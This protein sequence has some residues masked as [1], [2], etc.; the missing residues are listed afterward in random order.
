MM[1]PP[2]PIR[3]SNA[4]NY[5]TF[6]TN[7]LLR[8]LSLVL[9]LGST[10]ALRADPT[11]QIDAS[12]VTAQ[13]S[14]TLYG[15]M[16]EEIN[17]SYEGGLYGELIQNRIFRDDATEPKHW[18][19]V[20]DS[21]GTGTISLDESQPIEGTVLTRAL[22]LDA[23]Q[24]ST[25]H[26]VGIAN[27]GYWGI[28]VKPKTTY[29]LSFYAKSDGSGNGPLT[30]SIESN[31]GTKVFATAQVPQ[32]TDQW[33]KYT[34]TLTTG[35]DV[36]PTAATRFVISTEK[37]GT[38]WFN[39]VSLFPP[40]YNDR[41]NGNRIDIMQ[42]LSDMKPTFLRLPGGNFLEGAHHRGPLSVEENHRP[43]RT[44]P[45]PSRLLALRRQ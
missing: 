35:D 24:A 23:S 10:Q 30:A 19:V 26:R 39:L 18:S 12:K 44:T 34:A 8:I 22:K 31:D 27:D 5:M 4:Q 29:R 40:T 28:P 1:S 42:L 20:Q 7:S 2:I 9:C 33:Q 17:Y 25:G 11:F 13:V 14:P 38:L 32:I 36:T 15:L 45:R 21:G 16:T 3:F 41:P 43:A 6:S 37:P